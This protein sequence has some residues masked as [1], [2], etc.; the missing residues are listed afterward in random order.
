MT[1]TFTSPISSAIDEL[2]ER[3]AELSPDDADA[4]SAI[5]AAV[6]GSAVVPTVIANAYFFPRHHLPQNQATPAAESRPA[7]EEAS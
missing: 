7:Q 6:I 4:R 5:V 3:R 1:D 2:W